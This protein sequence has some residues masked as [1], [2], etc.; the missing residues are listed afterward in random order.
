M[1]ISIFNSVSK[2][3]KK[4]CLRY[5]EFKQNQTKPESNRI[6]YNKFIH[7]IDRKKYIYIFL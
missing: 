1:H 7:I 2:K 4:Y 5:L 3:T 6:E